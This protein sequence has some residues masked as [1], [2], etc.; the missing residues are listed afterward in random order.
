MDEFINGCRVRHTFQAGFVNFYLGEIEG[1][2][3]IFK[4]WR[5][6]P[7]ESL[8]VWERQFTDMQEAMMCLCEHGCNFAND[9][10]KRT[11]GVGVKKRLKKLER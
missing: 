5:Q 8:P 10:R 3:G 2:P 6:N 9:Q 4:V 1:Q 11:A 7:R